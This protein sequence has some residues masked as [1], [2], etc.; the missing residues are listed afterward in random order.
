MLLERGNVI[1]VGRVWWY[2]GALQFAQYMNYDLPGIGWSEGDY[3]HHD[4]HINDFLLQAYIAAGAMYYDYDNMSPEDRFLFMRA[5]AELIF[6]VVVKPTCHLSSDIWTVI[7]GTLYSGG[8]ETSPAGTWSTLMMFCFF[9]AY[10]MV[11]NPGVRM[12]ITVSLQ[13]G[14]IA[15]A[16]YGDDHLYCYPLR[17]ESLLKEE[18]FAEF[19]LKYFGCIIRDSLSHR[20]FLT[21][22]TASGSMRKPGP[23]FLKRYFIQGG[24]GEVAVLPFKPIEETIGKLLAPKTVSRVDAIISCI[25][26]AWDTMFTNRLAYQLCLKLYREH[27]LADGRTPD[28]ILSTLVIDKQVYEDYVKKLGITT[29]MMMK[30]PQYD[31]FRRL[32]HT[33]DSA[34]IDF[35]VN[36]GARS[37]IDFF[38]LSEQTEV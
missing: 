29:D 27:V 17:L 19:S 21:E 10:V 36:V 37:A 18:K 12:L 7:K 23:K 24:P 8:P 13:K 22:V 5:H 33:K 11:Y 20:H 9:L 34:K 6:N 15:F 3:Y 38:K 16:G 28:Q 32:M 14:L 26:Q 2:G 4:K 25:G 35:S 30:F 1:N 31:Y